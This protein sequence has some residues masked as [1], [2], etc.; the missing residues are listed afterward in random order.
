MFPLDLTEIVVEHFR[1]LVLVLVINVIVVQEAA[2]S[3]L[4]VDRDQKII[5]MALQGELEG[6]VGLMI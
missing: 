6:M 2:D 5:Q 4:R 3:R 1:V